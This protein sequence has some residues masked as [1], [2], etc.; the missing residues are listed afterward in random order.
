MLDRLRY[1]IVT[2]PR[3]SI[4]LIHRINSFMFYVVFCI[5]YSTV[6]FVALAKLFPR[7]GQLIFHVS[8]DQWIIKA[9]RHY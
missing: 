4:K 2:L 1:F 9:T 8:I 7:W 5:A 3:P 6:N